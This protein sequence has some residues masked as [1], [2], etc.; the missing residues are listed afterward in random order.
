MSTDLLQNC[1]VF[2]DLE[3]DDLQTLMPM[4]T[5]REIPAGKTVFIENMAGESL[6]IVERGEVVVSK[7]LA[8][9]DEQVLA[10]IGPGEAFGEL[11]IL[12]EAPRMAT[13]RVSADV[14]VWRLARADFDLLCNDRPSAGMRLMRNLITLFCQRIRNNNQDYREM[15]L[16]GLGRKSP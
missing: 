12:D 2:H 15:I 14:R 3:E 8:E 9:G 6:Y 11:A 10:R 7:M 5:Q 16:L 13:A 1:N 4:F